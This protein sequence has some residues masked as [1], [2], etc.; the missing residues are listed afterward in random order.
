[1]PRLA[2]PALALATLLATTAL[3]TLP[4]SAQDIPNVMIVG[5]DSDRDAVPRNSQV[6]ETVLDQ[7]GD[8]FRSQGYDVYNETLLTADWATQG[9]QGR[10][11]EELSK[12][13][14]AIDNP[15][16]DILGVFTMYVNVEREDFATFAK[17]RVKANALNVHGG[18][19]LGTYTVRTPETY[20]LP[21]DCPRDCVIEAL[22][23]KAE[24]IGRD[25]GYGLAQTIL[26]EWRA[27]QPAGPSARM[28]EQQVVTVRPQGVS[29][30]PGFTREYTIKFD[31]FDATARLEL[32]EYLASFRCFEEMTPYSTGN[33]HGYYRY[34][35]CDRPVSLTRN[36][37]MAL[38]DLGL[39]AEVRRSGYE[40]AIQRIAQRR[41]HPTR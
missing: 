13:T 25:V 2:R 10:D 24:E 22:V 19:Q 36:L 32:E 26:G 9:R 3:V 35:S 16:I 12:I 38:R 27:G 37:T 23:E 4:A 18:R 17:V 30:E 5:D 20:K 15:I 34:K 33:V 29:A 40:F 8:Q 39:A 31:N 1:M 14:R 21:R 11:L 7:L 6:F 28:T 41:A